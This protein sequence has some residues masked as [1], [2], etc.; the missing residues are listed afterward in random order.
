MQ[1]VADVVVIGAG[2]AGLTAA[3]LLRSQGITNVVVLE[4]QGELGGRL[5]SASLAGQD[6]DLG[7]AWIHGAGTD[8]DTHRLYLEL[9]GT[10]GKL[11]PSS[12]SNWWLSDSNLASECAAFGLP[13]ITSPAAGT[14]APGQEQEKVAVIEAG[15]AV[16]KTLMQQV[17]ASA[18]KAAARIPPPAD[19][20]PPSL[21]TLKQVVDSCLPAL[22]DDAHRR[23]SVPPSFPGIAAVVRF[24]LAKIELW[25]GTPLSG[26]NAEEWAEDG[27]W[28]D[29][30]GP[31]SIIAAP[32][33]QRFLIDGLVSRLLKTGDGKLAPAP[34]LLLNKT[35]KAVDWSSPDCISVRYK[36]EGFLGCGNDGGGSGGGGGGG[37][38]NSKNSVILCRRVLLTVSV[39]VLRASTLESGGA[40]GRR[41]AQQCSLAFHPPLPTWKTRA[42]SSLFMGCY[43]KVVL[44]FT[45]AFW[46]EQEK[47]WLVN[48][49][50]G[51]ADGA[52]RLRTPGG[53]V[54]VD[55]S[56]LCFFSYLPAKGKPVL[57]AFST[58]PKL[59]LETDDA[60]VG[61]AMAALRSM[62]PT[63]PVPP[64]P[65]A[66][67]V[68]RWC[69]EPWCLGSYSFMGADADASAVDELARPVGPSG[70][71]GVP[72][73]L[74]FAG[75]GTSAEYQ[76]CT[77][78]AI[79]SGRRAAQECVASLRSRVGSNS[80]RL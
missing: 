3:E 40:G 8:N 9:G 48:L 16:F 43:N 23:L 72:A 10:E 26:L 32:G 62:M 52:S 45:S 50:A 22:L 21:S 54:H 78:G 58:D 53:S 68:T 35:V 5:K 74:F 41:A 63:A 34:R 73:C 27:D 61:R 17:Q 39:G 57:V 56:F 36:E 37:G 29:T 7:A 2:L 51:G 55:S 1:H 75:E 24:Y 14:P 38:E 19:S 20:T 15:E 18:Q 44:S 77:H 31:H 28:G 64:S 67:V 46:P 60:L 4:H 6:V 49:S 47:Q 25:M 66:S 79:G 69:S 33:G 76:G 65:Q 30:A 71:A 59:E 70:G 80:S 13:L 42:L 12:P 11:V